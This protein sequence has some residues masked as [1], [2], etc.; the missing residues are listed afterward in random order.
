MSKYTSLVF[1]VCLRGGYFLASSCRVCIVQL[2]CGGELEC[3]E[4]GRELT[5]R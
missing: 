5:I 2:P 3:L 1:E 4:D